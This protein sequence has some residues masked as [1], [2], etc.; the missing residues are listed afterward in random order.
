MMQ[1]FYRFS[2][3]EHLD[4]VFYSDVLN[5]VETKHYQREDIVYNQCI[6]RIKRCKTH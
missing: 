5:N 2:C 1:F 3:Y 4:E 6:L